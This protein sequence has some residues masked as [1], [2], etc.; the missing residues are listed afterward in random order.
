[1]GIPVRQ[2]LVSTKKYG[3]KC[4]NT[5]NAEY[6]TIHNTANDASANNEVQYMINNS[7]Q[8]SFHFAIDDKEV[9]QGL[10]LN[11]NAWHCGDGN[12]PGNRKSIGVEICYS[13][14][15]G[16]KYYQAEGLAIQ[17]VAQLLRERGWGIDRV[18]KH[19]DWNG[20]HC[21]HRILDEGR[22]ASFLNAIQN[23]LNP[24]PSVSIVYEAHLQEIGW[25]G[26][27][28]NGETAGTIG[29]ARRIEALTV[30]LENSSARLEMEGHIEGLGWTSLRTN[31]EI[32]GTI[33]EGL[34]M[35]AIKIKANGLNI[36]YRV[37]IQN[38]GWT[39][40]KHNGE[41]AGTTGQALR[42]EAI[43]IKIV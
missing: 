7:N 4:P 32:I 17:F 42:I 26:K 43:E 13:K 1:M 3:I 34:R 11:H 39:E 19:K 2:M 12:G 36:A 35:E 28:K 14:S 21:P 15:G 25:Q 38:I 23:E 41:E 8:V 33:G 40:W 9:V 6:I 22:W 18:K 5:L 24:K 27:K 16:T 20:K 29:E 10:P 30:K 31:G 37:H